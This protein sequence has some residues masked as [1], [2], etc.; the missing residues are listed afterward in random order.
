[1]V[2]YGQTYIA[3]PEPVYGTGRAWTRPVA[4]LRLQSGM[5]MLLAGWV[6]VTLAQQKQD[7]TDAQGQWETLTSCR[8]V[9]NAVADGDS[10]RA[11][12]Q[13]RD[14]VFRLYFV[15]AP[16]T[17]PALKD[18]IKDQA[19]YFGIAEGDIP[20]AGRLAADFTRRWLSTNEFT[21]ITRWRNAMGRSSL[22]RFYAVV[23][24]GKTNLAEELVARGLARI[25][26]LRANWPDGPR[27]ATFIN[28][29]KNLELNAREKKLGIWNEKEFPRVS[30]DAPPV[31]RAAA[32]NAPPASAML[33]DPNTASNEELQRLPGIGPKLAERIIAH[34]PYARIEDLDKVPGIG[35]VTLERLKP[36]L[37][38]GP[39]SP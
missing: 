16:E 17:D 7:A 11:L 19:A 2:R 4:R 20:R 22:A 30:A 21:V 9:T 14:Y 37:R 24:I 18:R 25:Y 15:D 10:F 31:S 36:R 32:T 26:G 27:S 13:E 38:I 35:P 34:R 29:L 39:A 33:I 12:H 8:L 23:L 1:M 3:G 6:G 28:H 5:A